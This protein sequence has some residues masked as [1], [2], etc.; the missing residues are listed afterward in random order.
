M[1]TPKTRLA[2]LRLGA[3]GCRVSASLGLRLGT[4]ANGGI[5]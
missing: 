3:S 1:K 5:R 2:A 4:S